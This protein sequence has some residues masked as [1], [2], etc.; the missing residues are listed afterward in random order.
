MNGNAD[1]HRAAQGITQQ[2]PDVQA[3]YGQHTRE[4]WAMVPLRDGPR[5]LS[6]PDIR[7]LREEIINARAWPWRHR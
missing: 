6:A 7:Q 2:F 4:W 3:W 5:L 1:E